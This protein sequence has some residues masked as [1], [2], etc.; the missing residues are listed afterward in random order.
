MSS[1]HACGCFRCALQ[2]CGSAYYIAP[3]VFR[4][5]FTKACDVWNL[6]IILFLLLSGTVPFGFDVRFWTVVFVVVVLDDDD[7]AVVAVVVVVVVVVVAAALC[8]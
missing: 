8:L 2:A 6:G 7:V 4:R 1:V 5:S 3:E